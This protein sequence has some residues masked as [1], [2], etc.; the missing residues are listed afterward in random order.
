MSF[1]IQITEKSAVWNI[2]DLHP[3][4]R[5]QFSINAGVTESKG[6]SCGYLQLD[7]G[8]ELTLHSHKEQEIYI[9]TQGNA[10]LRTFERTGRTVA[11]GQTVYIPENSWHGIKNSS[12]SVVEFVWIFPTNTWQEVQYIFADN[13][14]N[15][16]E[17]PYDR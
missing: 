11:A 13:E 9:I 6:L 14:F 15:Q 10:E 3:G 8:A 7:P 12:Q 5:W 1:E 4:M 17:A 16:V 2:S